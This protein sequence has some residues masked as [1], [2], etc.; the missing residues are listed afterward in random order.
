MRGRTSGRHAY[1]QGA[2]KQTHTHTHTHTRVWSTLTRTQTRDAMSSPQTNASITLTFPTTT[3]KMS[4]R[5]TSARDARPPRNKSD[6]VCQ[7][8]AHWQ[9]GCQFNSLVRFR[10]LLQPLQQDSKTQDAHF[11]DAF[12]SS[13][14]DHFRKGTH[15]CD[16]NGARNQRTTFPAPIFHKKS[17]IL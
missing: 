15:E 2:S 14:S 9:W 17:Q 16:L 5:L 4:W 1:R 12:T 7:R 6:Q 11:A 3:V 10:V 8:C 13:A